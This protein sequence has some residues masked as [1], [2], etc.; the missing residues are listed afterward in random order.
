MA[1]VPHADSAQ[2]SG[3][4]N[5]PSGHRLLLSRWYRKASWQSMSMMW[6]LGTGHSPRSR[7]YYLRGFWAQ[8][9]GDKSVITVTG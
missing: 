7:M 6:D 3:L 5:T 8:R 1:H 2:T 9:K 4:Q